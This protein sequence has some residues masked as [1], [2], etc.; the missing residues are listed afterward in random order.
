MSDYPTKKSEQQVLNEVYDE[1]SKTLKVVS[2]EYDGSEL[3][4][5][6]SSQVATKIVESGSYVYVCIAPIGTPQA[7]AGW[8]CKKIDQSTAGT[9]VITW[10]DGDALFNNIATDPTALTY[11]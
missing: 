1:G 2:G 7:T 8:Q 10:A 5:P 11:S 9:T 4:N 3:Q 6:V